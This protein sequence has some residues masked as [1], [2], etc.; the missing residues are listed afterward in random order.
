M[1]TRLDYNKIENK[2][3]LPKEQESIAIAFYSAFILGSGSYMEAILYKWM[4]HYKPE[5]YKIFNDNLTAILK[6]LKFLG[7]SYLKQQKLDLHLELTHDGFKLHII[8][9]ALKLYPK[10]GL[11][12]IGEDSRKEYFIMLYEDSMD[13]SK[14]PNI[15]RT[16]KLPNVE[17]KKI[18][19]IKNPKNL[20]QEFTN[21]IYQ[22]KFSKEQNLSKLPQ[23]KSSE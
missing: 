4:E 14:S 18:Q 5:E 20:F 13:L 1:E 22:A 9:K 15:R 17:S 8:E 7:D 16:E 23:H 19:Y 21:Y 6:R 10:E 3:E 12:N 11:S 2:T